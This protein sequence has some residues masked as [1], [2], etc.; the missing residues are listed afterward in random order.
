MS[1]EVKPI[2][3][4]NTK[5]FFSLMLSVVMSVSLAQSPTELKVWKN[6]EALNKA[7]FVDKDSSA[8]EVLVNSDVTYGHSGGNV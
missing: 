3:Y 8:L 1:A 4:M 6:V 7:I 5:I 2:N